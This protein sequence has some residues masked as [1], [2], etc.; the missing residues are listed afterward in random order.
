[1]PHRGWRIG[2]GSVETAPTDRLTADRLEG[3]L[4]FLGSVSPES[5]TDSEALH[6][7]EHASEAEW[8]APA[9]APG[10]KTERSEPEETSRLVD[11][12]PT[13]PLPAV[14]APDVVVAP[15]AVVAPTVVAPAVVS[16]TVPD[17]AGAEAVVAPTVVPEVASPIIVP[18]VDGPAALREVAA[19][20]EPAPSE[21]AEAAPAEVVTR[22]GRHRSPTSSRLSI[23]G[24]SLSAKWL[25]LLAAVTVL[26]LLSAVLALT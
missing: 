23:R 6:A 10:E 8:S 14:V 18:E 13:A 3:F 22:T 12:P 5:P 21:M 4:N 26:V 7:P 15:D 25:A 24:I 17:A 19:E 1:M 16:A 2:R 20:T 9:D 11:S